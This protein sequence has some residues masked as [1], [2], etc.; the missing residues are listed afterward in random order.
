LKEISINT[1]GIKDL[2]LDSF[3]IYPNP[4]KDVIFITG[5]SEGIIQIMDLEGR[6]IKERSIS[7]QTSVQV[8]DLAEGIY[9]VKISA[10]KKIITKK[11][12]IIK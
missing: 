9:L 7:E 11:L 8:A 1:S 10:D 12:F 3:R 4:A 6:M 2:E 5:F